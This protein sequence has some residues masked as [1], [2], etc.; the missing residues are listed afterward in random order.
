MSLRC[1]LGELITAMVTPMD[2][3]RAIDFESVEKISKYLL[4]Q[5]TD[6]IVVAGTTGESPT[7]THDEEYELLHCVKATVSGECKVI[8]G[9]GSNCTDTAIRSSK[10]AQELGADAI[11]SVVPY[12][13][14]PS[15][16]GL[17]EHFG[18]IAKS[19]DIPII[20]YNIPGRT[21]ID[22]SPS[23][24]A[25]LAKEYSNIVAVK[26]SNAN[27]DLVSEIKMLCPDDFAIYSGD[28]SLTLPMMS[29]GAHGVVSVA[30]HVVGNQ[31]K[32]MIRN[33]KSGQINAASD[34]HKILYPLFKKIFMAPNP[35]PIK[36]L[37][38]K[39]EVIQNYVRRPLVEL[40]EKARLELLEVLISVC[41]KTK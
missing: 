13:N 11:L 5:Q 4:E 12:Y 2:N 17:I 37:L 33:F 22:M 18:S 38:S 31:I 16:E 21:G 23:T 14:K 8:M 26:Q 30:S 15:Q 28:D 40:D 1:D 20:L 35:T 34:M 32:S 6:A 7:L 10:K 41:E 29:I 36:A 9:A 27:L 39:L 24:I 3:E 25:F 19:I